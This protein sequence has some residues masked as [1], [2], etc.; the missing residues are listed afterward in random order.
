MK[1]VPAQK[2]SNPES[3]DMSPADHTALA[4]QVA[5]LRA[6]VRHAQN[7]I[8]EIKSYLRELNQRMEAAIRS[9]REEIRA[10]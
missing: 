6:N 4:T 8:T 3:P 7:D 1:T 10:S 9:L 2:Y 5:E